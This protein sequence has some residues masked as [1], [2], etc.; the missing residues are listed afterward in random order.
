MALQDAWHMLF[1]GRVCQEFRSTFDSISISFPFALCYCGRGHETFGLGSLHA[2]QITESTVN[3][4]Q[5][6]MC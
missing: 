5:K 3:A 1:K 2:A 4:W 6:L